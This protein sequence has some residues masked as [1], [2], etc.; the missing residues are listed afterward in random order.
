M[1][2]SAR[3]GLSRRGILVGGG[4]LIVSFSLKNTGL[5]QQTGEAQNAG[6]AP[7]RPAPLPGSLDKTP[8]LDAWIRV[9]AEG[10]ISVFTGKAELGQGIKTAPRNTSSW[11]SRPL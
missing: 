7:A 9:D 3:K 10:T 11:T 1:N 5:A 2:A 8:M 6:T 4:A